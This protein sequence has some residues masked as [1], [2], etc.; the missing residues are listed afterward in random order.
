MHTLFLIG[1]RGIY[2]TSMGEKEVHELDLINSS[3]NNHLGRA[4]YYIR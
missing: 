1:Y 3:R 2:E 4:K